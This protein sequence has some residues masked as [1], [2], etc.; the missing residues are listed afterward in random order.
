MP[1]IVVIGVESAGKSTLLS[2]IV[3]V[4]LTFTHGQTGTRSPVRY[5]LRYEEA[6]NHCDSC[7]S[8]KHILGT[9]DSTRHHSKTVLAMNVKWKQE[10]CNNI[11]H[12]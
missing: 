11:P 2:A 6:S 1:S 10:P 12:D 9:Q 4:P 3:G 8:S 7:W 5:R